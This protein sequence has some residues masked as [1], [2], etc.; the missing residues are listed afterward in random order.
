LQQRPGGEAQHDTIKSE[1]IETEQAPT[2]QASAEQALV[3]YLSGTLTVLTGMLETHTPILANRLMELH[4][5]VE[6][7]I[8]RLDMELIE[9][10]NAQCRFDRQAMNSIIYPDLYSILSGKSRCLC[11]LEKHTESIGNLCC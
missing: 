2:E 6:I 7:I 3:S 4:P 11:Y 8:E 1:N 5:G 9:M 10:V